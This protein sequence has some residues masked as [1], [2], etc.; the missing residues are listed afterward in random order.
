MSHT[1]IIYEAAGADP[2]TDRILT[3]HGNHATTVVA[4]ADAAPQRVAELAVQLADEGA[5]V[6]EL[7]GGMGPVPHAAAL[8]A[9]G[10]R[11]DVGSIMYGFESLASVAA[12]K[13]GFAAG[14]LLPAAFLYL[15]PG[16]DAAVDRTVRA[17]ETTHSTFVAV[18]DVDTAVTVA[19]ELID[20]GVRLI[21]LY[22]GLGPEAGARI[23]TATGARVPVG[24]VS[25]VATAARRLDR[26]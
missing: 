26:R 10:D 11:A 9:V 19:R 18:P 4:M 23:L 20:Q 16:S 5:D 17:D 7:C 21:E 8:A 15:E 1:A 22:G 13:A 12:Y 14:E 6:I 3:R 25:R 24:L 2:A